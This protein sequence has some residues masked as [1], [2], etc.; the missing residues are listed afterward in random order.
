MTAPLENPL[1]LLPSKAR[2]ALRLVVLLVALVSPGLLFAGGARAQGANTLEAAAEA[3]AGGATPESGVPLEQTPSSAEQA[4]PTTTEQGLLAGEQF[5]EEAGASAEQAQSPSEQEQSSATEDPPPAEQTPPVAEDP[6]PAEQTPPVAPPAEQTP[7]PTV[8]QAPPPASGQETTE[9]QASE[10]GGEASSEGRATEGSEGSQTPAGAS[11][12]DH[13]E[14]A[15]EVMPA[16]ST[17]ATSSAATSVIS[18]MSIG[19][20]QALGAPGAP[21]TSAR[22]ARHA[23]RKLAVFEASMIATS[24]VG[25]WLGMLGESPVSAIALAAVGGSPAAI[26]TGALIRDRD[27][28]LAI[29][30]HPSSSA[31]AP[32]PGPGP[33]PGG[34]GGGSAA[35]GASGSASSALFILVNA[36]LQAAPN[37]MLRLYVSQSSWRTSFCALILERP[38]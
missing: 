15:N 5:P 4:P 2:S 28:G 1:G 24:S 18:A 37:V 25:R 22:K 30:S 26:A 7:P 12:S 9:K 20:G 10:T 6:P 21:P 29:Q 17:A 33:A 14:P 38:D 31:P 23:S 16:A 35:G 27:G 3:P 11:G 8:E 34:A 13:K 19:E 36:P 32:S